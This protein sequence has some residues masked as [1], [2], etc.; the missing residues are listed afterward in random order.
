MELLSKNHDHNK[1]AVKCNDEPDKTRKCSISFEEVENFRVKLDYYFLEK[2]NHT[3]YPEKVFGFLKT[4]SSGEW[5]LAA[6][7]NY[8]K[9][10]PIFGEQQIVS[11][12]LPIGL[13]CRRIDPM[14]YPR[15]ATNRPR[16]FEL[17]YNVTFNH[18]DMK[19]N[20][21]AYNYR[22]LSKV[23]KY[24]TSNYSGKMYVDLDNSLNIAEGIDEV[25]NGS[26]RSYY[27]TKTYEL[28]TVNLTDHSCTTYNHSAN[29]SNTLNWFFV[30]DS[31]V[32]RPKYYRAD[33][34]SYLREHKLGDVPC[35]VFEKKFDS[36]LSLGFGFDFF[37]KKE[38]RQGVRAN[39]NNVVADDYVI[40]THYQPKDPSYWPGNTGKLV[41]PKRIEIQILHYLRT[42]SYLTI[43]VNS[44]NPNPTNF[45]KYDISKCVKST[46]KGSYQD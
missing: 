21:S 32:K 31:F 14:N 9:F 7:F 5:Q 36:W 11:S 27:N 15:P 41:V 39:R 46:A 29:N 43:D 22:E 16:R 24:L 2:D 18:I 3:M 28:H 38:T 44:F 20:L 34:Y 33:N 42:I 40:V 23:L 25:T 26:T 35:L 4:N 6:K 10:A 19:Q 17:Q 1:E 37:S 45:T 12:D 30:Q 8:L 13:G